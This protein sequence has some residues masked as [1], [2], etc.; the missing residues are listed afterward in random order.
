MTVVEEFDAKMVAEYVGSFVWDK[1]WAQTI[2]ADDSCTND[3]RWILVGRMQIIK[4]VNARR[5]R[6]HV[7]V[8]WDRSRQWREV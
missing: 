8:R 3:G 1:R 5:H 2:H 7:C 6:R 4:H